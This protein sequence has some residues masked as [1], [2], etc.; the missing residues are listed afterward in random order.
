MST[1]FY[2]NRQSDPSSEAG[3]RAA[4]LEIPALPPG[5]RLITLENGLVLIIRE[6]PTAP[7]V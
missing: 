1:K 7:V 3:A 2:F 5:T 4:A 6:D